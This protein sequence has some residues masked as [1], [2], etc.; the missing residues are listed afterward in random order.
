MVIAAV[1]EYALEQ[2][3]DDD[4]T[5]AQANL[6]DFIKGGWS[7]L[8]VGSDDATFPGTTVGYY[9]NSISTVAA[10]MYD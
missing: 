5:V 9:T 3:L 7:S 10:A 1:E 2:A 8:A 6:E 4:D